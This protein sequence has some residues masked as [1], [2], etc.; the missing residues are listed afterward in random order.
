MRKFRNNRK[1]L[2]PIFATL[3]LIA[4]AVIA[5]IIVYAYTTGWFAQF[6]SQG[7]TASEK[8][9]VQ[10]ASGTTTTVTAYAQYISGG[11]PIS[12]NGAI[13]T[14]SD[15]TTQQGTIAAAVPLPVT[16]ALTKVDVTSVTLVSGGTYTVTLTSSKGGTFVSPSFQVP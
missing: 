15:G 13:V 16:G 14:K 10:A 6:G 11:T 4:I 1:G 2:S 7:Q 5:G 12:I 3:I 8:A 9:S